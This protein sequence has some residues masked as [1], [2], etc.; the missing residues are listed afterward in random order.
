M[1]RI[2]SVLRQT[3]G[4]A[5]VT[6]VLFSFPGGIASLQAVGRDLEIVG[7]VERVRLIDPDIN[8]KAKLDTGAETSSLDVEV[9]KKFRKEEKRWVR[10]RLIDP[11]TGEEHIIVRERLRTVYIVRHDG[12]RQ[13]RPVV[14][15]EIC[16]AGRVLETEVSL[17]DRSEFTYPLLLGRKSLASFAL[18]DPGNTYLSRPDCGLHSEDS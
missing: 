8:L 16:I 6:G 10:F 15:M 12:A 7:W 4:F 13:P 18:I 17:I 9:V 14:R 11:E 2:K 1:S 5:L 3:A